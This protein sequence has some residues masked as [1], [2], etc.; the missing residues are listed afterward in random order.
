M[1]LT[2]PPTK[3]PIKAPLFPAILLPM[4]APTSEP[5]IDV[6]VATGLATPIPVAKVLIAA[7]LLKSNMVLALSLVILVLVNGADQFQVC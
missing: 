1:G 3:P 7:D 4:P 2:I 6:A 5:A